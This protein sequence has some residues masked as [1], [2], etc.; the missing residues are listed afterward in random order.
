MR[1]IGVTFLFVIAIAYFTIDRSAKTGDV[2]AEQAKEWADVIHKKT[3]H[4]VSLD[5]TVSQT[6]V[7]VMK[8]GPDIQRLKVDLSH[9]RFYDFALLDAYIDGTPLEFTFHPHGLNE[10][11]ISASVNDR[12]SA[13]YLV[14]K[15][16][17]DKWVKTWDQLES[18]K[19]GTLHPRTKR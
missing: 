2:A 9:Q 7:L 17:D 12:N 16:P 15:T 6:V 13:Y 8:S 19:L 14:P 10:A 3:W 11:D 5:K 4:K 18:S 1:G